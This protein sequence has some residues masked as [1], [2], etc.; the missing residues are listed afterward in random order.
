[1]F[2]ELRQCGFDVLARNHA[3]AIFR[4]DFPNEA[5]EL[6]DALLA[7]TIPAEEILG[8]GGGEAASTQRLRRRLTDLGWPKHNFVLE[9]KVDG[10]TREAISHEIDHVRRAGNGVL[11]L[12]I[13]WNNK[14]PFFDRDLENFQRLHAQG[15]ISAGVIVTRGESLQNAMIDIV[16]SKIRR[17][18]IADEAALLVRFD[19]MK[20]RTVRQREMVKRHMMRGQDPLSFPDAFAKTFVAD[21]FGAATTHWSKLADR[22]AR[23]VGAPCPLLL[24]GLPA[25]IVTE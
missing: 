23:G 24:I 13:E 14:D 5:Q 25:N 3:E 22:V 18:D 1:M 2:D 7:A 9:T 21:K 12:E 6:V 20:D 8:S 10:E 16:A 19:T 4:H 15:V 11:A 17:E